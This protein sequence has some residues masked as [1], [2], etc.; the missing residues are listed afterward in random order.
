[1]NKYEVE[2]QLKSTSHAFMWWFFLG[3]HYAYLGKWFIQLIYWLT[4][5]GLGVW[6]FIDIFRIS[7]MV[8]R[9]NAPLF[10]QLNESD[11]S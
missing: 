6:A 7:G 3:A 9:Y 4:L 1:M 11:A 8:K 2:N 5:G 10:N